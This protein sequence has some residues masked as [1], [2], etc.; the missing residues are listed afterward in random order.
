[1]SWCLGQFE[2]EKYKT[3]RQCYW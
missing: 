1:M 3:M 2:R